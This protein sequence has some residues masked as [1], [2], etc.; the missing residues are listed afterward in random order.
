ME[1]SNWPVYV[2]VLIGL[3]AV[4][5]I[6]LMLYEDKWALRWAAILKARVEGRVAY[7]KSY[8][9]EKTRL[10]QEYGLE[11]L[12]GSSTSTTQRPAL[13]AK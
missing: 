7:R 10:E 13:T 4:C 3:A 5:T 6:G 9:A 2:S 1:L 11:D 12:C 8:A